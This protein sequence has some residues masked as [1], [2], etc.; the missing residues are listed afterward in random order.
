MHTSVDL[1]VCVFGGGGAGGGAGCVEGSIM[2]QLAGKFDVSVNIYYSESV[3]EYASTL[4]R[5][6][7]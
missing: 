4:G 6:I 7:V 1:C 3:G 5:A 2:H